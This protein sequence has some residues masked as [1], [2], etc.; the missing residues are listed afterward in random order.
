MLNIQ[1]CEQPKKWGPERRSILAYPVNED[2][3]EGNG[4]TIKTGQ[5]EKTRGTGR[6]V[7]WFSPNDEN[8][9]NKVPNDDF[10]TNRRNFK[11]GTGQLTTLQKVFQAAQARGI[12]FPNGFQGRVS[13]DYVAYR[14]SLGAAPALDHDVFENGAILEISRITDHLFHA[15]PITRFTASR[16]PISQEADHSFHAKPISKP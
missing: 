8:I 12:A 5:G 7:T 3:L 13:P 10:Y 14:T 1:E 15:M 16:S 9:A 4:E 6:G 2:W 11:A